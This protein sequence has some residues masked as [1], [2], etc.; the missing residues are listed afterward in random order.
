MRPGLL[1][2]QKHWGL[3]FR[4]FVP[5]RGF[6]PLA[7]PMAAIT[8]GLAIHKQHKMLF[9]AS[10]FYKLYQGYQSSSEQEKGIYMKKILV[11]VMTVLLCFTLIACG[12]KVSIDFPFELSHVENVEMFH[13]FN[14]ADAE[15]K[16]ITKSEDI[17]D[18][19]Q[20]FES[21]SLKGKATE[22]TA[23]GSVTSF[24]FNL[25]DGTFYE[26]VYSEVDVKSGRIIITDMGQD[27]FTSDN[28]AA[29]W[30]TYDYE[31]VA[32]SE[33]ELPRLPKEEDSNRD[34]DTLQWD[35]I[36]MVMVNGRLYYDTGKE[37]TIEGR[38]GVMDGKITS[39]VEDSEIPTEDNQSNFGTGFE[40]QY[41]D[42]DTIEIFMNKKW[43]VFEHRE[44]TGNQVRFGDH[45]VDADKL[46]KETL[47][48]LAWYN[49]LPEEDQ[50]AVNYIPPDLYDEF[51]FAETEDAES[52][53]TE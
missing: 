35:K 16:V 10:K 19:Y 12:E 47:E 11:L 1:K 23:G 3:S 20:I 5:T 25:S 42:D 18:I 51:G 49:S 50:L 22:P 28:I 29:N 48:W 39:N 15:K 27:F 31:V 52:L 41:G 53:I 9:V 13:C 8:C 7:P 43:I 38:C 44:D 2:E 4:R 40:Y 17:E 14:P 32:V 33:D 46:S 30:E 6:H 45:I 36:L 34:S 26:I 24:R 21:I 37:S